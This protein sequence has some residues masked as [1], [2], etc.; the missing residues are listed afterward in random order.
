MNGH[1]NYNPNS[2]DS[3]FSEVLTRLNAQDAMLSAIFREQRKTN[4]R[5]TKLE[6]FRAA[7]LVLG[8]IGMTLLGAVAS[9]VALHYIH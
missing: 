2:S 1:N 7:M 8:G 5:V 4:G 6:T 9:A 3:K